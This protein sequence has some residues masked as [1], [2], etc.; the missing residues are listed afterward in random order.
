MPDAPPLMLITPAA[1]CR[2]PSGFDMKS[3]ALSIHDMSPLL[4]LFQI[5]AAL[6]RLVLPTP[7]ATPR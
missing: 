3:M 7:V 5:L 1:R 2:T 4:S 6:M